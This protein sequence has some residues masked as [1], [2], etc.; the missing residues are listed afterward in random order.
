MQDPRTPRRGNKGPREKGKAVDRC[1][2]P[3][4]IWKGREEKGNGVKKRRN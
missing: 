3:V 2:V 1:G 4:S